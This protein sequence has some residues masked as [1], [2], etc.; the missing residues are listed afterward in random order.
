MKK[1]AFIAALLLLL[2]ACKDELPPTPPLP[3]AGGGMA[4]AGLAA[5]MPAWAAEARNVAVTPKEVYYGDGV[6]ISVSNYDY[7]YVNGYFFNSKTRVWEKFLL[8]GD[9]TQ[10]WLK[11]SG[12]GSV[13]INTEKFGTGANYLVVYACS[14]I[15]GKWNCN[16][17]K[18]MLV[19]FSVLGSATGTIPESANIDQMVI[20]QGI[21]PLAIVSTI[22]EKD[23][24]E[25]INVIRYDARY[26]DPGSGLIVL[27]HVFDFNNRQEVDKTINTLFR[28]IVTKGWKQHMG[29]NLAMFLDEN[30]RRVAVWTSGKKI[31]YVETHTPEFGSAEAINAYLQKYP[32]DLKK[33]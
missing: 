32:S 20:N 8:A 6:I 19:S 2:V 13:P 21:A 5:G 30:D 7:V 3:G 10:D 23:N 24:F 18:W 9:Q 16:G 27:V 31:I 11:V 1:I 26:R 12:V 33:P 22:A 28:D 14:K 29:H 15:E 4:I 17:N 25:E